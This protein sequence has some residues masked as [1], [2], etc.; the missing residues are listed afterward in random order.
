MNQKILKKIIILKIIK[1]LINDKKFLIYTLISIGLILGLLSLALVRT[2][3]VLN[4]GIY[5]VSNSD[6]MWTNFNHV[7]DD[8]S[9]SAIY[10]G[11]INMDWLRSNNVTDINGANHLNF[12]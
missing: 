11:F 12:L 2:L 8:T 3:T 5:N 1:K 4:T 7:A 6:R 9:R 10:T